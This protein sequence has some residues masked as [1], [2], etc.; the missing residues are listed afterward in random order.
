MSTRLSGWMMPM[1][2]VVGCLLGLQQLPVAGQRAPFATPPPG[3]GPT[4]M[5][6]YGR[7][8]GCP[9]EPAQFHTCA[10]ANAK[11]FNPPRTQDGNPDLQGFWSRV[12]VRNMENIEEHPETM[13]GSGG[14]SSIIDPADGRIP[15]QP[16]AAAKR[17]SHFATYLNPAQ[18]CFPPGSPKYA[19]GAGGLRVIQSRG[20]VLMLID[21]AHAFRI[22][23]TDGRQHVGPNIHLFDGDS[24]GRW[25]GNTLVVDVTNQRDRTWLDHVGNFYSD[26]VHVVERF[27]MFHPDVI[28]YEATIDDPNVYTRPWT[29]ASGW[30]RNTDPGFEMWENACWEGVSQ[31]GERVDAGLKFYP[32]AFSK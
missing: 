7:S 2:L 11:T 27:T 15:Y 14:T 20:D 32:G 6:P 4:P 17:D 29:M 5:K 19:Y 13:D 24:R 23:P 3:S 22:I 30:A 10:M 26:A 1:T 28:H 8:G 21:Y 9:E 18:R 31:G 12:G 25:E 16:W